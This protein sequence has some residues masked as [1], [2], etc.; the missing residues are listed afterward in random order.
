MA[1]ECTFAIDFNSM[2]ARYRDWIYG[3][4]QPFRRATSVPSRPSS[5]SFGVPANSGLL[6]T[7][8]LEVLHQEAVLHKLFR[9]GIA[10]DSQPT[11]PL[12]VFQE[13]AA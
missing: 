1:R 13:G 7:V 3:A 10:E 5:T 6:E 9:D 12:P 11:M 4:T 2:L 8:A